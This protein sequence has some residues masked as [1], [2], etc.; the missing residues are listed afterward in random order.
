MITYGGMSKKPVALPTGL[1][2]FQNLTFK[3]FWMSDWYQHQRMEYE[4][5]SEKESSPLP[6]TMKREKMISDIVSW[7]KSGKFRLKIEK[8]WWENW[9]EAMEKA[10]Q[11]FTNH[12]QLL[13]FDK[14]NL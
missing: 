14:E 1:L 13:I 6:L 8:S 11:S 7:I 5:S 3:G 9:S 10:T 12:K 2:I 4:L